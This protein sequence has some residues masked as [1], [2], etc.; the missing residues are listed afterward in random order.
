MDHFGIGHAMRGM[1]FAYFRSARQTGRTTSLID[2]LKDGDRVM[3]ATSKRAYELQRKCCERGLN[4]E[5]FVT[6]VSG[7]R[8]M[9]RGPAK[10]RSLFDSQ[11]LEQYYMAVLEH[12]QEEIDYLQKL[13]SGREE[14]QIASRRQADEMSKWLPYSTS[15]FNPKNER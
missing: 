6:A 4:V 14:H 13:T 2:S 5:C 10:G 3:C 12:A 7:Q 15:E 11:W 1:A 8:V 9:E